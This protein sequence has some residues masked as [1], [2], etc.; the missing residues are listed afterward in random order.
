M[1]YPLRRYT[2]RDWTPE[3]GDLQVWLSEL[4]SEG[5]E[6][7]SADARSTVEINGVWRKRYSLVETVAQWHARTG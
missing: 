1:S 4:E 2:T 3:C 6:L 5:W 7:E